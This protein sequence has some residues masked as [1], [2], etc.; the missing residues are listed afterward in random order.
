MLG[1]SPLSSGPISS[2][3]ASSGGTVA[4]L[5]AKSIGFFSS[6]VTPNVKANVTARV[7]S[8]APDAVGVHWRNHVD[9]FVSDQLRT[10][11]DEMT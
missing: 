1:F 3:D 10:P 7:A 2:I 11:A 5:F 9:D 8:S 4:N 6:R